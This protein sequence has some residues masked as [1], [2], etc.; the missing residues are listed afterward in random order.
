MFGE[1]GWLDA[2]VSAMLGVG[3]LLAGLHAYFFALEHKVS[4]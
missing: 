3:I 2:A 4:G 1:I